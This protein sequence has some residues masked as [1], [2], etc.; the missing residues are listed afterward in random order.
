MNDNLRS[1]ILPYAWSLAA[2]AIAVGIQLLLAPFL[3]GALPFATLFPAVFLVAYLWGIGP[4]ALATL[5][6]TAAALYFFIEPIYS[7]D[8]SDPRAHIGVVLFA[9]SSLAAG[10]FGEVWS[11]ANR[12]AEAAAQLARKEAGIARQEAA[13]AQRQMAIAAAAQ[14]ALQRSEAELS[15][16][17]ENASAP[18]HWVA[19]DGVVLRANQAELDMLGYQREEYVGHNIAEF[20]LDPVEAERLLGRLAAGELVR[21]FPARLRCKAGQ[22]KHVLID[23]SP[24]RA[25][26]EVV[27]IRCLTRDVTLDQ[28]AHEARERL[29]AIVASSSDAI[30]GKTLD[31]TVTSWNAAAERIF[32]YPA[33]EMVGQSV[34][35]LIPEELHDSEREVLEQLRRGETVEFAEAERIRRDGERIWISL[36]VSPIRDSAGVIIGAASIKRDVTGRRKVEAQLRQRQE[37]LQLAHDAARIG[38]WRW[39]IATNELR[40]DDGLRQLYGLAPDQQVRGFDDFLERVHPEDR[41]RVVRGMQ[42]ALTASVPVDAE[43]RVILPDGRIRWLVDLGRVT[44]DPQG[45]P[46]YITGVSMDVTERRA[47]EDHL[48]ETQR[49]QAV[50]QL[51][52]GIAHEANNQM[53]V[54][55]GAAQFL[56]RR[57]DLAP[58]SRQDIELIGQAAERTAAITQ[59]LLAFSRRQMLQLQDVDLNRIVQSIEPVLRRSLAENH[60]LVVRKAGDVGPV[61]VDPRQLEQV[62]L[63][64]TLNARDAMPQGGRLTIELSQRVVT[65]HETWDE[66]EAP[67]PGIYAV[68]EAADTGEGMDR[69]TMQRIFEP[70][71]TT[72][73]LG[74]GTGLG[75]SVVHGIIAQT[76]GHVRVDSEPGKGAVFRLYLP[77]VT[78][79]HRA[80]PPAATGIT[81][82]KQ[83]LVALVVEDDEVVRAMATR[84]LLE[85]GY[86]TLEAVNGRAAL[87][88]I[89]GLEGRLD[90]VITDIGMPEMDGYDLA[91]HLEQEWRDL[92]IVYMTGYGDVDVAGPCLRKPFAPDAL[93]RKVAEVLAFGTR[94]PGAA[95]LAHER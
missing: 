19:R 45:K 17:F 91:R 75:L 74:Q 57:P 65:P 88:L 67:P 42:Q 95:R 76:G 35:R 52:G 68:I 85:A 26:G 38:V 58:A 70:F 73:P 5:V 23:S 90:V 54:V 9:G 92:P 2:V 80:E 16:F 83:G 82:P 51:A 77:V 71:F 11:R 1:R 12:R 41:D 25:D 43:F 62:L 56:L 7:F 40:W 4:T 44:A 10:W 6:G 66:G 86:T 21:R 87:E 36:S 37:E 64:L 3:G 63:N 48:R 8:L 34:F 84:G 31:G 15:D 53:T 59:Q 39:D 20:H 60:E 69:A 13:S 61:Q 47:V 18:M 89:R 29:A 24:Y 50:G 79:V 81:S 32:G 94:S 93:V 55:L 27:H 78:A 72:K 49:L 14:Q 28:Q 30:I 22:V 46:A 33:A